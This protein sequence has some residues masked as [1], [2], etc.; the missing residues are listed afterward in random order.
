MERAE[1]ENAQIILL[2]DKKQLAAISAGRL[3]QDL[4]EHGL[5]RTVQLDESLRQRTEYAKAID[6]AMKQ[7]DVRQALDIMQSAGKLIEIPD[8]DE[9]AA[10]MAS[11]FVTADTTAREST[12]GR[13]GALAMALTNAEREAVIRNVREIQKE[14]GLIAK[15]DHTFTTRAP[16]ALDAVTRKLA[17]SYSPGMIAIPAKQIGELGAGKEARVAAVDTVKNTIT[18]TSQDGKSETIDAR[19]YSKGMMIYE[20]RK[21]QLSEGEKILWLKTDN[22]VQG[23]HNNIKNGLSG[24]IE[25]IEG[26]QLAVRTELG[27]TVSIQGE[28][29][30]ITNA[31]AITG[32]KS[33]GATE[34]TGLLSISSADKLATQS[35]LY[36]LTTRQ[37]HDL[38]AFV[39]DKE[40]LIESLKSEV[41]TS[42][43][44]E[45]REL[46]QNLTEQLK[47]SDVKED[48][49]ARHEKA[50]GVDLEIRDEKADSRQRQVVIENNFV[51]NAEY[52]SSCDEQKFQAENSAHIDM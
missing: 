17:A 6:A 52:K 23:K 15:V 14:Q 29:A 35:M 26:N 34:H 11:A 38:V 25:K 8:R 47:A 39:D 2:G 10:A 45:Q 44:E 28:G 46:L 1:K 18:L 37:T 51:F 50:S 41:K 21:T 42:S 7:G 32:H 5:V 40:K 13:K 19:K 30:Y 12:G 36:V 33:Q 48:Q 24:I 49:I 3:G 20:E 22:T 4:D 31:Q 16:V 9:R 43:L 27:H